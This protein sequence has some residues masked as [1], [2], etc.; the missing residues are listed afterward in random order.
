MTDNDNIGQTGIESIRIANTQVNSLPFVAKE[1]AKRD[2]VKAFETEKENKVKAVEAKYPEE[3]I[4]YLDGWIKEVN[5]NIKSIQNLKVEQSNIV[6][7]YTGHISMCK[8]R[9]EELAKLDPEVPGDLEQIKLLKKRF[10]PYNVEKM[11]A[12]IQM[13]R[14]SLQ[15]CDDV[16]EKEFKTLSMLQERRTLC[17][18]R[19]KELAALGITKY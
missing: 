19:N 5:A 16:I 9:D 6:N 13:C 4:A 1:H 15:R 11:E 10:P 7:D 14:D 3:S 2:M 17:E 12:Q 8:Y 18:M